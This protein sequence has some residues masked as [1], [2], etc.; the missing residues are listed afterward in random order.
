MALYKRY[1]GSF[2]TIKGEVVT[3]QIWQEASNAYPEIGDLDF[4]GDNPVVI[5]WHERAKHEPLCGSSATVILVSPGDRTYY[6]LFTVRPG[7][8]RM[9]I[10]CGGVLY[11]SGTLDPEIAEEPYTDG[12]NYYVSLVFSD[13]G[14]LK[15][16]KYNLTGMQDFQAILTDALTRSKI[17]YGSFSSVDVSTRIGQLQVTPERIQVLSDNFYDEEGS[18]MSLY[19]VLE[20]IMQPLGLRLI[21]HGGSIVLYDLNGIYDNQ[22][23]QQITWASNDQALSVDKVYNEV[24]V[25]FSPY[26]KDKLFPEFEYTG[27]KS[28]SD[29]QNAAGGAS[30][31]SSIFYPD[32]NTGGDETDQS[33]ALVWSNT[34]AKGLAGK[35]AS[36]KYF[37]MIP[38]LGGKDMSG[39]ALWF[40]T[41]RQRRSTISPDSR[42]GA[43]SCPE[44]S[45]GV[46]STEAT[47]VPQLNQTDA[48]KCLIRLRQGILFDTR[49][50]PF[51]DATQYNEKWAYNEIQ[52]KKEVGARVR[53]ISVP[54]KVEIRSAPNGSVIY[55][56]SNKAYRQ[57]V[58]TGYTNPGSGI[59]ATG[60]AADDDCELFYEYPYKEDANGPVSNRQ[61]RNVVR[62]ALSAALEAADP[63]EYIPYPPV[64]GYLVVTLLAGVKFYSFDQIHDK[65]YIVRPGS[66]NNYCDPSYYTSLAEMDSNRY[67]RWILFEAPE[68]DVVKS[69]L[70]GSIDNDDIEYSG[71][72]NPEAEESLEISE[73]C[74]TMSPVSPAA[75]GLLFDQD[76]VILAELTRA[77]RTTTP[78]QLLI[79]TMLSHHAD[80]M[81]VLS[82]TA[83]LWGR[84][85]T[86]LTDAALPADPTQPRKK[87]LPVSIV[88][89][90]REEEMNIRAVE[91]V[92]D[93]YVTEEESV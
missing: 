26:V 90:L 41:Q 18:P 55:H 89:R 72:I 8:I 9:D 30:E 53:L 51:T 43:A 48:D 21:Q 59:W 50:N 91:T 35:L 54:V 32:Y 29:V 58:D 31:S 63:G 11:W 16:L 22:T 78:E 14:I 86:L 68:L 61:S 92:P 33:F 79:G 15:R 75:R 25:T 60:A 10:L 81:D 3:C 67:F 71:T 83:E 7:T 70:T 23:A 13:F 73:I 77:G 24:K 19:E 12:A 42:I 2:L 20:G 76:G 62:K 17:N 39:V 85:F 84:G 64:A 49:Y 93:D 69:D 52:D 65:W 27:S 56:Y 36:A 66:G 46:L 47:Y 44:A 74:G 37:R 88:E 82:G 87:L 80:R 5:E 34:D 1:E 4:A 6:D 38:I 45:A 57:S 28:L 40:Y